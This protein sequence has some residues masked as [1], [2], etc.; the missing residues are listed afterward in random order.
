MGSACGKGSDAVENK[1]KEACKEGTDCD[2]LATDMA[3]E[4]FKKYDKDADAKMTKDEARVLCNDIFKTFAERTYA[5]MTPEQQK[6]QTKEEIQANMAKD[7]GGEEN[8]GEAIF[9]KF[10]VDENGTLNV[11]ELKEGIFWLFGSAKA[12]EN[13]VK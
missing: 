10:D 11:E 3:V 1:A 4:Y 9:K 2:K 5:T 8:G 6:E 13:A 7:L 12:L